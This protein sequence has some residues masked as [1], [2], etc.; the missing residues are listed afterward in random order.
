MIGQ[1]YLYFGPYLAP[2]LSFISIILVMVLDKK[3][4]RVTQ[5]LKCILCHIYV[6]SYHFFMANATIQMSFFTN[7]FIILL[8]ISYLNKKF[9]IK[10][11]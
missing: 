5:Y 6:L 2:I 1:G 11:V 8:M 10:K 3:Y 9:I 4:I 7:F